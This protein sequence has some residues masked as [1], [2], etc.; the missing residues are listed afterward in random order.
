[1]SVFRYLHSRTFLKLNNGIAE[2]KNWL[3]LLTVV[4]SWYLEMIPLK[5]MFLLAEY[6][7][8]TK[9]DHPIQWL[10]IQQVVFDFFLIQEEFLELFI[11]AVYLYF[12]PLFSGSDVTLVIFKIVINENQGTKWLV[13]MCW[14]KEKKIMFFTTCCLWGDML[15]HVS[16]MVLDCI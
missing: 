6:C 2:G 5:L 9:I 16:T 10:S 4:A 1:M 11:L 14:G 3:W 13:V 12:Y 15:I 7:V 8:M